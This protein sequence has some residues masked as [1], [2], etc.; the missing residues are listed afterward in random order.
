MADKH[1]CLHQLPHLTESESDFV[2]TVTSDPGQSQDFTNGFE[3]LVEA[4]DKARAERD[5]LAGRLAEAER[6]VNAVEK[7]ALAECRECKDNTDREYPLCRMTADNCPVGKFR[8][9]AAA[10][11][12][13]GAKL[14]G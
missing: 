13:H 3:Q 6:L 1:I 7:F 14:E 4:L 12:A 8:A 9:A 2:A 10:M 5:A 11:T